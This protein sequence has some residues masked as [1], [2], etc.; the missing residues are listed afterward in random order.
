M[1]KDSKKIVLTNQPLSKSS[2]LASSSQRTPLPTI[3][4]INRFA[5]LSSSPRPRPPYASIIQTRILPSSII[6][7]SP[8]KSITNPTSSKS[9]RPFIQKSE[10]IAYSVNP[11]YKI[12]KILE[13]LEVEKVSQNFLTL[14]DYLY[15]KYCHFYKN[16]QKPREYYQSILIDTGSINIQ[17]I[18]NSQD[19][20][21]IDYSKVKIRK[22]ISLEEWRAKPFTQKTLSNFHSYPQYS[23]Y[24]YQEACENTFSLRNCNHSWFFY[25]DEEFSNTYPRW[26]IKWFQYMGI[27]PAAFPTENSTTF[28]KFTDYFKQ[29]GTHVFEYTLQFMSVFRIPWIFSWTYHYQ[30]EK[31]AELSPLLLIRHYRTKW[32]NKFSINK[33]D[34]IAVQKFYKE[35]TKQYEKEIPQNPHSQQLEDQDYIIRLQSC[36]TPEEIQRIISAIKN[37]PSPSSSKKSNPEDSDLFQDSQDPYDDIEI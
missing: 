10:S 32:W 17:H 22:I 27:I 2:P 36:S 4:T 18:F 14:I 26:F 1:S 3:P 24:D 12:I 5:P 8:S 16:D 31:P 21:K 28:N 25:F 11:N 23:Y 37:S 35:I 20:S 15:P 9:P 7:S 30:E 34:T 33:A 29:E 13:P 6:N 19:N